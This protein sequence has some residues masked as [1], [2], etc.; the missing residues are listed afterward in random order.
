MIANVP[1]KLRNS[2]LD[3]I[4]IGFIINIFKSIIIIRGILIIISFLRFL[5]GMVAIRHQI[6][7]RKVEII[8]TLHI[9]INLVIILISN[10]H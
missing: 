5:E 8:M 9:K 3:L 6:Q 7:V 2:I 1:K 10:T 4:P